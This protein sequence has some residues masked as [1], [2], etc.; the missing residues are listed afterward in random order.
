MTSHIPVIAVSS[1]AHPAQIHAGL[2]AGFYRYLT[3]PYK[4]TDLLDAIDC[5]LGYGLGKSESSYSSFG[6]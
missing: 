3:K 2:Q 5:S 4:L 6:A 1:D